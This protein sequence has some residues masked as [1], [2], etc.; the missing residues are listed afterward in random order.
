MKI[1]LIERECFRCGHLWFLRKADA[2]I[3]PKCKSA[4]WDI[5]RKECVSCKDKKDLS[6][7]HIKPRSRGGSEDRANLQVL[8]RSCNSKKHIKTINF[9]KEKKV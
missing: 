8:C 6:I 5:E 2:R 1:K 7:D 3:C 9:N 4:Y